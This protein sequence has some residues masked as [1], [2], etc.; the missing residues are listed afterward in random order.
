MENRLSWGNKIGYGVGTIGKSMSYGLASGFISIYFMTGLGINPAFLGV[1]FF[2]ARLW[3]G[4][5]DLLMGAIIDNTHTKW[6]KFRP[7][8][9][10]GAVANA[11]VTVLLFTDPGFRG[12]SL[13]VYATVC[14]ILWDMTYTMIDVSYWAMIPALTLEPRDRDQVSMLPRIFGGAAGIVGAFTLQIV[15][16]LGGISGGGFMKY[17]M[18]T[19]GVYIVTV[20]ICAGT[21]RERVVP[22]PQQKAE[23]FSLIRSARIL[24]HNDQALVIVVIMILFNLAI[25]LTNAVTVFYFVFVIGSRDQYSFF[26]I[27][28]GA[29]QAIGLLGYPLFSRWF[30]RN[31]VNIGSLILPCVGYALMFLATSFFN[32]QFLPFAAAAFVMSVGFGSM[33]VMQ[34]VMLAD[35]VDYGEWRRGERH[36][37]VIFSMLTFLSKVAAG[38][39]ALITMMG[40]AIVGFEGKENSPATPQTVACIEFMMYILPPLILLVA[41]AV[42]F[43]KFRLKPALVEQVSREIQERRKIETPEIQE[44]RETEPP[45]EG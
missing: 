15:D 25:N 24:F 39:S 29:S 7:W 27:L 26:T 31:R 6:G 40:F 5:N 14:F 3:D 34:N 10:L 36:E 4:V 42:Y 41:L 45:W 16:G 43:K 21:V 30:G 17:A 18:I 8:M 38:L 20:L 12:V 37:G 22:P 28:L 32:G 33:G 9:V 13:Y 2:V 1:M 35:A 44:R 23:K 11:A 19:S